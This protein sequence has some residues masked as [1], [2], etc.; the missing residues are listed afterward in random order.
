M[1]IFKNP[2]KDASMFSNLKGACFAPVL[3]SSSAFS[4]FKRV[5][6]GDVVTPADV[7][8]EDALKRWAANAVRRAL[9]VAFVRSNTDVA[10]AIHF[11][12][13]NG[14]PIAVRGGG[15]NAG[16]S[17]SSENGLVVD[18]SRYMNGCR[19]DEVNEL[20]YVGGGAIWQTVDEAAIKHGL[21]TVGG[22]VNHVSAIAYTH[23]LE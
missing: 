5:F 18:L 12:R 16:G 1:V 11:A 22:T 3:F 14:L 13:A 20:A 15:H 6:T 21:A 7:G 19:I 8:Y 10:L 23:S 4:E 2:F 9:I 17:S